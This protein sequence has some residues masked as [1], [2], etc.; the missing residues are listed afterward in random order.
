MQPV[1]APELYEASSVFAAPSEAVEDGADGADSAR[2]VVMQLDIR[3]GVAAGFGD[4]RL[5]QRC[6]S[7]ALKRQ[8]RVLM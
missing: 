2:G 7:S 8:S 6:D 3:F 1:R 5:K 4:W